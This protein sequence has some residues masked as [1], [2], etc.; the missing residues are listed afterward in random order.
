MAYFNPQRAVTWYKISQGFTL[1]ELLV[2]LTLFALISIMAYSG[3]NT[4]LTVHA[5]VDQ[6]ATQ[7]AQLQIAFTGLRRDLEQA[8]DRPIRDEYGDRQ[9]AIQGSYDHLELTRSGWR[10]PAQR[11]RSTLQ[12]VAYHVEDNKLWRAYWEVLDRSQDSR[13]FQVELLTD[14]TQFKLRYLDDQLQW[15]EQWP[16][17]ATTSVTNQLPILPKAIEVTFTL[18]DWGKL[19]R[20]F[21]LPNS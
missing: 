20:L 11:P 7:L 2:A 1:L 15:H 19:T 9:P 13:P 6:Q 21:G 4:I 3:L 14:I 18:S 10:N 16:P 8:I 5:H 17:L 12:R